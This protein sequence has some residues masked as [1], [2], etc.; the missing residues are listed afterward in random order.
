MYLNRKRV[1]IENL[2]L[3]I[4][5]DIYRIVWLSGASAGSHAVHLPLNLSRGQRPIWTQRTW[6][7]KCSLMGRVEGKV[8]KLECLNC[9][10]CQNMA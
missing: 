3:I 2:L 8:G 6:F 5:Y 9:L 7:N 1:L 10:K 4:P